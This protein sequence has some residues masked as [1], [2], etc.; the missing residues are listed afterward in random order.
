MRRLGAAFKACFDSFR[1]TM[2]E[3]EGE[4]VMILL[5]FP[6][7]LAAALTVFFVLFTFTYAIGVLCVG[8]AVLYLLV[9]GV[10]A[11]LKSLRQ[12]RRS[13]CP[14]EDDPKAGEEEAVPLG[15][16]LD[17]D[18]DATK[19]VRA[20]EAKYNGPFPELVWRGGRLCLAGGLYAVTMPIS[21]AF[22]CACLPLYPFFAVTTVDE[23][24]R[25]SFIAKVNTTYVV[26]GSWNYRIDMGCLVAR[27]LVLWFR[28]ERWYPWRL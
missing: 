27:Q 9:E 28:H 22:S 23:S 6:C 3:V 7:A 1:E 26:I 17:L 20:W 15:S 13:L 21:L 4:G 5:Y 14:R 24:T 16:S 2:C 12:V 18:L 25:T 19:E 11:C 10:V 8:G